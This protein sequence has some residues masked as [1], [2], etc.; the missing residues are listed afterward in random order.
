MNT[1]SITSLLILLGLIVALMAYAAGV[2][3]WMTDNSG[4]ADDNRTGLLSNTIGLVALTVYVYFGIRFFNR[5]VS[6][7]V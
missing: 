4:E 3:N 7:Q 2:F 1:K 5:R 6:E